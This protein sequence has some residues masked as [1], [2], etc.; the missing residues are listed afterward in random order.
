MQIQPFG[1]ERWMD[2]YETK[3][4]YN[5]AETCVDSMSLSDLEA[6][7]GKPGALDHLIKT[8]R[9]TYGEIPGNKHFRE[10]VASL[11]KNVDPDNVL[12]TNG[13]IGANFLALYTLVNPGDEV[14][15]IVPTYQQHTSIPE[16]LGAKVKTVALKEE[17]NFIPDLS[18]LR[19]AVTAST[20]LI[21][22]NNPNNPTGALIDP[23]T[24]Q[25]IVDIAKNQDAWLLCDEVYRHLSHDN[26]YPPS[27][28]ELYEKGISTGSMSKVFS[29]AG[30]R[31]GWLAAPKEIIEA[32]Y[33]IRHYNMISCGKI[34]EII[35]AF[36]LEHKSEILAR[37]KAILA[38]NLSIL[39]AWVQNEPHFHYVRP[40]A[41][42]TALLYFDMMLSSTDFCHD[43]MEKE[44][45][46]LTPGDCFD[47]GRC[48]RIGYAY[49][50]EELKSGL[51]ALSRYLRSYDTPA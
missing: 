9:M 41:G 18:E 10:G 50:T 29:L 6:L 16:S 23:Q 28:V 39:D 4:K 31:L 34:D 15:V 13:A 43:L 20:K 51:E 26:T 40:A 45:V 33:D 42:T 35:G 11:Y 44:G 7:V 36:A 17:S 37:S 46:M 19:R 3:C 38:E 2:L 24:L 27:V 12:S 49:G 30:L 1:V 5:L 14:V 22:F 21:C 32:A 48:V 25:G 8:T 47:M